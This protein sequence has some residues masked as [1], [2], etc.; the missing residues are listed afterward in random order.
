[1]HMH[2]HQHGQQHQQTTGLGIDKEF[3]RSVV[4]IFMSPDDDDQEH[5]DQHHFPEDKEKEEIQS[6]KYPN[7]TCQSKE[8]AEVKQA[9]ALSNFV[10][11]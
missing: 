5:G 2:Q 9:T 10:P 6:G 11:G 8:Q 4:P 7:N 3:Q 1:M